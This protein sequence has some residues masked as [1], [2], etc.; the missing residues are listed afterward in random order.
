MLAEKERSYNPE[1]WDIGER[2]EFK[3]N[4]KPDIETNFRYTGWINALSERMKIPVANITIPELYI[5]SIYFTFTSLTSV[6]FGN[7]SRS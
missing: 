5:T 3:K 1:E 6:G 7:V 2:N 4:L